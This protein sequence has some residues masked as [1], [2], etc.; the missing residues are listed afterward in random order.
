M[1]TERRYIG[2]Y[3]LHECVGRSPIS[4]V[5]K[6]YD[7]HT[8]RPVAIKLLETHTQGD[9][10]YELHFMSQIESLAALHHPN[11]AQMLDA[12]V[13]PPQEADSTLTYLVT[14][15]IEGQTLA[16]YIRSTSR[17]VLM[18]AAADIVR[19]F[20]Y[21]STAIDYAHQNGIYHGNLKP[22]NVI[23]SP[24]L[25]RIHTTIEPIITDFGLA[26][27]PGTFTSS[28]KHRSLEAMHY[29][30]PEQAKRL[31]STTQS[32][33]YA[34]GVILYEICTGVLPFQGNRPV[35]L[36]MQHTSATPTSPSLINP[37]IS[38]ALTQVIMRSL[39]KEP[40]RRF[41][42]AI[43]MTIALAQALNT[44]FPD[45]L[46]HLI[47]E[48][49][50]KSSDTQLNQRKTI[51]IIAVAN[52]HVTPTSESVHT[53]IVK[54]TKVGEIAKQQAQE[55]S[56]SDAT[57][58][59][60]VLPPKRRK[61]STWRLFLTIS[62]TMLL[63]I[64]IGS[65]SGAYFLWQRFVAATGVVGHAYFVSSGQINDTASFEGVNDQLLIDLNALPAPTAGHSYYGWL[66]P[67]K[68][69]T[70]ISPIPLGKL[71]VNNGKIHFLYS[72]TQ[73][74]SDLLAITSRLLISE[75]DAFVTP[76]TP[77]ANSSTWRYYAEISQANIPTH[78][79][80]SNLLDQLRYLL[81]E[82]PEIEGYGLHGGL[83]TWLLQNIRKLQALSTST[84]DAWSPKDT[85]IMRNQL[86]YML[87]YLDGQ[88][89]APNDLPVGMHLF[90]EPVGDQI[91]LIGAQS[92]I[93]ANQAIYSSTPTGYLSLIGFHLNEILT[94]PELTSEQQ[95]LVPQINTALNNMRLW[96]NQ[97]HDDVK[98]LISLNKTQLILPTTLTLVNEVVSL[99]QYAY[100]GRFDQ[101]T[102]NSQ[103][104]AF[105]T[106][107]NIQH[108][109]GF[110]VTPYPSSTNQPV[111]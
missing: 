2:K 73:N 20:I 101:A 98:I 83:A 66:L 78:K 70:Q 84:R 67:D 52:A 5:W 76:S 43:A 88:K 57:S 49:E 25:N 15:Y 4:E 55:I 94:L 107:G 54:T 99:C 45:H 16:D 32:D 21:M 41:P 100:E 3:K 72:G 69:Q 6:A 86:I 24:T 31:A 80:G 65:G 18:P 37:N 38:S 82:S 106:Y 109:A 30:S 28:M 36:L 91:P 13:L 95:K 81:V 53:P 34:L 56:T 77:S 79:S 35:T 10:D 58:P 39:E 14:E 17:S 74:H 63:L 19:L 1:I 89:L 68:L 108:L 97:I 23:L 8:H 47:V 61:R 51:P 87:D 102:G 111:A 59:L 22:T 90:A 60:S 71:N 42:S 44:S 96:L 29:I 105:W 92:L 7:T 110:T 33:I 75:E 103:G 85:A 26:M 46:N 9:P 93:N 64:I 27:L 50:I 48:E 104:G 40:E 11:I 62:L 12:H